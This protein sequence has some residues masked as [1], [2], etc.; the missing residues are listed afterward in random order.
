MMGHQG[1]KTSNKT[2][3]RTGEK[4]E[5]GDI[6]LGGCCLPD[7]VEIILDGLLYLG[8]RQNYIIT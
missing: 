3:L 6:V 1:R 5:E 8:T 7:K 4:V 2:S